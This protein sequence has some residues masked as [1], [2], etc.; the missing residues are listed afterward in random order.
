MT[1]QATFIE[2]L[3]RVG[4]LNGAAVMVS[5]G[6]DVA[7]VCQR[8]AKRTRFDNFDKVAD[9]CLRSKLGHVASQFAGR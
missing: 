3:G 4:A 2:L 5:Q 8:C 7:L 6:N 1:P 9:S